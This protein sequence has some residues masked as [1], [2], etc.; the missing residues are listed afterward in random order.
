MAGD[1]VEFQIPGYSQLWPLDLPYAPGVGE[2]SDLNPL[3]PN[4][5]RPLIEGEWLEL[6]STGKKFTRGGN[7]N[8]ADVDEGTKP[9][10]IYFMERGRYDSQVSKLCHTLIG[11]AGFFVRTK[12]CDSTGLANGDLVSVQDISVG[13]IVRRGLK[14]HVAGYAVGRVVRLNGTNDITIQYLPGAA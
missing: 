13:G 9:A 10:F 6:D 4:S 2:S 3:D 11:P 8:A 14:K 7:N 12:L 5:A 1:Y